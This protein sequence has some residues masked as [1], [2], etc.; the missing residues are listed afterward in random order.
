MFMPG[1]TAS[2]SERIMPMS[3]VIKVCLFSIFLI[4]QALKLWE[5]GILVV[6]ISECQRMVIYSISPKKAAG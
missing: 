2:L 1:Q 5:S 3:L 6:G 4:Q